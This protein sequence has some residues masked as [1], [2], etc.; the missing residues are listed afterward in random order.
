MTQRTFQ[1]F[2]DEPPYLKE[3]RK[4]CK[5]R[6]THQDAVFSQCRQGATKNGLCFYHNMVRVQK[7]GLNGISKYLS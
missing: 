3:G 5:A 7:E 2:M 1:E 6:L 4:Q